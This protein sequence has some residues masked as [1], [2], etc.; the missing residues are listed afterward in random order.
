[1]RIGRQWLHR[2][3]VYA[4]I[5]VAVFS[6]VPSG[7]L[8]G[9]LYKTDAGTSLDTALSTPTAP[10][11][12]L[13]SYA[14]GVGFAS[15]DTILFNSM[16]TGAGT[17]RVSA[18]ASTNLNVSGLIFDGNT[19]AVTIQ[20]GA[21]AGTQ[22]LTIGTGG[23]D[24]SNALANVT[25]SNNSATNVLAVSLGDF[26]NWMVGAG[27]TLRI[28]SVISEAVPF[29]F[30]GISVGP[31]S[32]NGLGGTVNLTAA[33]TFTGSS[34]VAGSIL[35]LDYG[36]A[37]DRIAS[38]AALTLNR[39]T[40]SISGAATFQQNVAA[41]EL[42]RGANQITFTGTT[43][44][45]N[46]ATITRSSYDALLNVGTASRASA[47]AVN[48]N[49]IIGGWAVLNKTDW[50]INN[51]SNLIIAL[52][53]AGYVAVAA[54]AYTDKLDADNLLL[55]GS[56]T[57][58]L[59][60]SINSIKFASGAFNLTQTAG[61][62]LNLQSGG[63]LK[64]D[65]NASTISGGTITAGGTPDSFADSL[66]VWQNQNTLTISSVIADNTDGFTT[67]MVHLVKA[68]DGTLRL[69]NTAPH[70]M[71]GNTTITGG[72]IQIGNGDAT[73]SL[74]GGDVIFAFSPSSTPLV[75]D[76][77]LVYNRTDST[78]WMQ[79]LTGFGGD[80]GTYYALRKSA[81]AATTLTLSPTVANNY[82]GVTRVEAGTI[83]AGNSAAFSPNSKYQLD[84]VTGVTLDLAGFDNTIR[85]L[86]GGGVT[87]G[88][89]T[90]G[91]AT[92]T[93]APLVID[94]LSYAGSIGGSGGLVKVGAGTQVASGSHS[95]TGTT[96]VWS[97]NL[98]LGSL[99][100]AGA[101]NVY[102]GGTLTI[103]SVTGVGGVSVYNGA[104][105]AIN[106]NSSVPWFTS[107]ANSSLT[108]GSPTS[109]AILTLADGGTN[110]AGPVG[111]AFNG[112]A[113]G[114]TKNGAATLILSGGNAF[115]GPTTV[116]NGILRLAAASKYSILPDRSTITIGA[117]GSVDLNGNT[118]T[119]GGLSGAAGATL[120]MGATTLTTGLNN[121]SGNFAGVI[122]GSGGLVK[123][124][125]GTQ[126]LSGANLF[127]GN[128]L[129]GNFGGQSGGGITI[130]A[131]GTLASTV[132][133]S[134]RGLNTV[135]AVNST[136]SLAAVT[137]SSR[138]TLAL[139]SGAVLTSTYVNG[140]PVVGS[141]T[142]DTDSTAG[143]IVK[144]D[145]SIVNP[146]VGMLV[147][148]TSIPAGSYIVQV[149]DS[150]FVLLNT[151]PTPTTTNTALTS[152]TV[153]VLNSAITGLGGFTKDGTGQ[154]LLTGNNSYSGVTTITNGDLQIGGIWNGQKFSL[155]DTLSD[156]SQLIFSAAN[157]TNL[158]FAN[159]AS[160][161]LS[162]ERVAAISGGAG[163]TTSINLFAGSNVA[164]LAIGR[165]NSSGAFT[166][167]IL[168]DNAGTWLIKE[169]TGTF[170]WNNNNTVG[171]DGIIDLRAGGF[172]TLGTGALDVLNIVR[173]S[174]N[175]AVFT[176]GVTDTFS[177][178]EGGA[179]VIRV[180]P[181]TGF[182]GALYGNQ[183]TGAGAFAAIASGTVM[184]VSSATSSGFNGV[185]SGPGG[186]TK[187]GTSVWQMYGANTYSG[188]TNANAGTLTLG[189]LSRSAGVGL[190]S[191]SD[192]RGSL[193]DAGV[194]NITGGTFN[195]NGLTETIGALRNS[196]GVGTIALVNGTLTAGAQ[197]TQTISSAFTGNLGSVLN[198]IGSA[199]TQTVTLTGNSVSFAGTVNVGTN[200]ALVLNRTTSALGD[201]ARVNLNSTGTQLTVTLADTIGSIAGTGDIVLTQ[202]LTLQEAGS[203][204]AS[205]VGYSG[206]TTNV[207][208][209]LILGGFGGLTISGN[210]AH[211]G[212]ITVSNGAALNL[213]YGAGNNIVPT[214]G[215]LTLTGGN[216]RVLSI[217]S[218]A[219]ILENAASTTL[220]PGASSIQSLATIGSYLDTGLSGLNLGAVTRAA[221]STL[222]VGARSAATSTANVNSIFGVTNAAYATYNQSTW[223]VANGTGA[224]ITGLAVFN[225]DT[226]VANQHTD[227]TAAGSN[228]GGTAATVRFSGANASDITGATTLSMGGILVTSGVG[229]NTSTISGDLSGTGNELIIHQ[230]NPLGNLVLSNVAG[231]NTVITTTG[232]GR[233]LITN[234]IAGT[235]ATNIGY[236]YL[237]LGDTTVGGS[238]TGMVGSGVI[239]NNGTLGINRNN[240]LTFGTAVISGFGNIEQL[241]SGTTTLGGANTFAGR[242]S[243]RGGTLEITSNTGLGL[244]AIGA[245]NRWANL[246]S[247][248]A[249]GTLLV[250]VAAGGSIT[251]LLNLD[252]GTLDLRSTVATTLAGPI[253][254]T[255]DSTINVSNPGAAVSHLITGEILALPGSDL[256]FNNVGGATPSTL[257]LAPTATTGG[258]WENTTI[259]AGGRLVIGNN[260]RGFIGT[261]TVNNAGL[262]TFDNNDGFYVVGNNITGAASGTL[263]ISRR[264][265]GSTYLTGDLSG[266]SGALLVATNT[267]VNASTVAEI[268]N[269]T[270]NNSIGTGPITITSGGTVGTSGI[271][272]LRTHLNQDAVFANTINLNPAHDG[273]NAKNAQFIR[274]GIG[275][276]TLSGTIN[277]GLTTAGLGT[278]RNLI[279]TEAGGKLFLNATLAGGGVS[280]LLNVVNNNILVIGGSVSNTYSGI[281]SG[282]NV[283][284]F[285][286]SGTTTLSGANTVNSVNNYIR[287]G[288]VSFTGGAA[289]NDDNDW[290]V[291]GGATLSIA[292]TETIGAL[293]MQRGAVTSIAA[294]QTLTVD[295]TVNQ[296]I[297]GSF[298]GSGN[299]TIS[300]GN[301]MAL[302]GTNVASGALQLGVTT[303]NGQIQSTNLTNAIGGFS[304]IAL[305][306]AGNTGVGGIDYVGA[307]E[308]FANNIA[309][310]STSTTGSYIAANGSGALVLSGN[311]TATGTQTLRLIGQTGGYFNPIKNRIDGAVTEAGASVLSIAMT[312]TA[313]D[314][315]FG[316]TGRWAL[317]NSNNDFSGSVT[318]NVGMLELA[319]NLKTGVETTSVFGD[320]SATR[321]VTLGSSDFD[322]RR[323]DM[324]GNTDQLGNAGFAQGTNTITPSGSV[325]TI[326]FNDPNAGTATFG[327]NIS[328][329]IINGSATTITAG[330]QLINDGTKVIVINGT[331]TAGTQGTHN[332][333]F[334]GTN[335]GTNTINGVISNPSSTQTTAVIKEGAGT[336]RLSGANTFTGT[337]TVNNGILELSGGAA[338]N[339][340]NTVA[341]SGDGGDGLYSFAKLRIVTSETFAVLTGDV[342]VETTIDAGQTLE[343]AGGNSAY[344]GMFTGVG[345]LAKTVAAATAGTLTTPAKNT[346][347]GATTLGALGA[348]TASGGISVVHLADGGVA[349]GIG[350]SS[351]AASNLVF[352]SNT[353]LNQGGI[354]TWTG[355][356]NQSTNRL[357][358]MG[359]GT[360]AA[361]ITASGALVGT[362]QATLTF[363]NT[364][365]IA[366]S[367]N[368]TR[369]LT[370]SGAG[371]GE[372][373]FRPQIS[374]NV[375][376]TT[377]AK[378]GAGLWY[379]NPG[380]AGNNYT[381]GTNITAGTLAISASNALGSGT[382]AING[383]AGVGLEIRSGVTLTQSITNSTAEGGI[384]VTGGSSIMSN[385]VTSSVNFRVAVEAGASLEWNNATA[386][387][388]GAGQLIKIG[389]GTLILSGVNNNTAATFVR[390]GVLELN[391]AVN[392]TSKLADGV[393]L[394]LGS[395]AG[396]LVPGVDDNVP[397][398]NNTY[399]QGGGTIN[400]SGGSHIE[401]VSATTIDTGSNAVTRT[402]GTSVLRM[403]AITRGVNQ[404]TIDFGA[405]GIADTDTTNT[406][407]ILGSTTTGAFATVAKTDWAFNSTNAADGAINALATY[408]VN[409]FATGSNTDITSAAVSTGA[410]TLNNTFRFNTPQA[411][412]L[413]LG[414][415]FGVQ[416]TAV[417][418]QAGGILVTPNVGAFTTTIT[419]AALQNAAATANFAIIVH[420]HNTAGALQINSVIQNNT[421]ATAQGLTKTG[422]GKLFLT[423]LNTYTGSLNLYEGE[424]QVGGTAAAPT[425][426]TNAYL[427]ALGA[428]TQG[429]ALNLAIDT[430]LRFL[431]TNTAVYNTGAITGGGNIILDTGNLGVLLF[432]DANTGYYGNITVNQGTIQVNAQNAALGD[433]RGIT[434]IGSLGILQFNDS[435]SIGEFITYSQGATVTTLAAAAGVL[436]GKQTL[437]NSTAA[438]LTFNI[439]T[440]SVVGTVGLN[441]SGVSYGNN[442]F[443]K[444][445]SGILQISGTNFADVYDGY[446]ALGTAGTRT[447][448][449]L[450]QILINQGTLY[451]GAT[452]ALGAF[453]VG[454]ET[455]VAAGAS[456]DL[457]GIAL[458]IGDD[459]DPAREIL[460][461]QGTG[462]VN[463]QGNSTGALR[464]STGTG[465]VSFVTLDGNATINSG[466]TANASA[467]VI[468][469]FDTNLSN[470]NS[471]TG[472]FTRQ[473]PVIAGG[474]F[475]L[476][477]QG[478]RVGTDNFVIADPTF[479][480]ALNR[481]IIREGGARFRHE[482]TAVVTPVG[483]ANT[484]ITA[485]I[486]IGYGG[487]TAADLTGVAAGG[488]GNTTAI[489]GANV[490]AR[491]LFENFY[492]SHNTVSIAMNGVLAAAATG[493]P[494]GTFSLAGGH[495]YLSADFATIP[496]GTTYLDG[497]LNL[498]GSAIRNII[499]ND[500]VGNYSVTEQGN[501]TVA[502]ATKL[503][504]GGVAQGTGGFTKIGQADVRFTNA[505][506]FSGDV[507]VLRLGFSA[508][509]WESHTYKINGVDYATNGLGEGW[510]EYSLTLN[511]AAGAFTDVGTITL[512]RRGMLTLDNTNRLDATSGVVGGNNN[513]RI[514]DDAVLNLEHGWFRVTAGTTANSEVLGTV[515]VNSGANLLDLYGTDGAGVNIN[516]TVNTLN[517]VAGGVL[518]INN[519]DATSTFST[520]TA[521]DSAKVT[522]LTLNVP[523]IGGGGAVNTTTRSIVQGVFGGNAPISLS[524]DLR[525]LGFNNVNITDLWNQVRNLEFAA[526][527][528]FMTYEGTTLRPLDDDEYFA[529]ADG[530]LNPTSLGS[531]TQNVNLSDVLTLVS[532]DATVNSLRLGALTD[533][534]GTGA[535]GLIDH[536]AVS[537]LV[538]G[539]L[540]ISSGMI[541][542]AYWT[543]GNTSSAST[544]I[545]GGAL[546]FDGKEA[547][548]NVQNAFYNLTLGAISGGTMSL[549]SAITNALGLTKVGF[550]QLN[551]DGANTYTGVT[552][553]SDGTLFL[554]NGRS[555]LGAGGFGNGVVII[556]NG[557]LN[558]GNGL[559]VGTPSA[560]E[561]IYVGI[562]QASQQIMR[563]DNDVTVWNSNLIIDN[564][565][566]SGQTQFTPIIR[567][568]NGATSIINGNIVGGNTPVSNDVLGNDPRR[569]SFNSAG[570]NVFIVR[571]Q[572]GDRL[573]GS[574][575]AVPIAD[576]I[577][578]LPTLTG[579]RT[580][581]NEVLRVDLGGASLETNYIFDRQYNAAGRL[582]VESGNLIVNYDPAGGGLDGTGYWTNT[583]ISKIPNADSTTTAF[584]VNGGS[585]FQGFQLGTTTGTGVNNGNAGL[586]LSRA[587]QV[588]NMAS[589]TMA[590][591]G[592]KYIG[593][594]NESGTVAFGNGTGDLT[595]AGATASLY[596]ADG[597][598]V[599]FNQ[600]ML[601]VVGTAPSA[602]G[603]VKQGRGTVEL[604]NTTSTT[605]STADFVIAGGT[606]MLNHTALTSVAL[607]G[608]ANARFDGGT[609]ISI[610]SSGANTTEGFA[611]TSAANNVLNFN[612]GGTE[613]V[614][615][616]VNTGTARNMTI[617]MGNANANATTSNFTRTLGATVNLVEDQSAGGTA[618]ITLEFNA[619]STAAIKNQVIPWATY[620]TLSR[621][622]TDFAMS[623]SASANDVRAYGR[624][625]G[626]YLNDVTAWALNQDVSESGGPGF[627]GTLTGALTLSTLRFDANADSLVDLGANVLTVAGNGL[628]SS[629]GGI[630]VSS[631]V[632]A[633]N[634]TITGTTGAALTTSGGR[635]ELIIHQYALG[636]LNINVPIT[637]AGVDLVISGPSTTNVAT[638]GTTGA[639]VLGA[640]NTY[641]GQTFING[642]VLSFSDVGQLGTRANADAIQ[643]NGGTLRYT[644]ST[645]QTLGT[646][647]IVFSGNG[648]TIDVVDGG[649]E[650]YID[651]LIASALQFRGDMIKVG[652]GTLTVNGNSGNNA[653]FLGLIDVRQGT[654]RINSNVGNANAGTITPLGS[655]ASYADGTVFR[656]GT[657]F[658][659]Q[660]GNANDAAAD[661]NLEEWLTFE[662]NNYV[663][664]GTI[665]TQTG[666]VSVTPG[667]LD[668]NN[669]R[670]VNLNGVITIKGDVVFDVVGGQTLRFNNGGVG[671]T[672]GNGNIIKDGQGALQFQANSPDFTGSITV[673]QG[674][675]YGVGQ[676]DFFGTGYTAANGNKTI[677]LGSADRQGIAELS[678][679]SDSISGGTMEL[680]H[681][682]N[683]VYNPAQGKRLYFE[684]FTNGSQIEVNGDITFNDNLNIYINDAAETGGSQNYV[685]VNSKLLDGLTTSGNILL[686]ADDGGGGANDNTNGRP[687][688]YLVLKNNN[689]G[690]TGD[691][692][693][694][695]NTSYDQDQTAI[696]RLEHVN[697]LTAANDVDMGFN[698]MLQVG[699]GAR[700][701]GSLSTNG[702]VGPFIGDTAGGTMG[703]STNG[704][705]VVIENA[706]ATVGTLTITQTTPVSTEVVWNAYFRNGTLNSEFFA[707]GAGPVA[708]AALNLVKAGNGWATIANDNSYTGTTTVTGGLLQVGRGNVG[709][710]GAA[711]AAGLIANTGT[712]IAGTGVIQGNST[713]NGVLSPGDEGGSI[714]GTIMVNGNLSLGAASNTTMQLQRASYTAFNVLNMHDANY[715]AWSG[716][717][718]GDPSY[719]HLL[720]DPVTTAQHDKLIVTGGLAVASGGKFSLINT[721]YNPT[722]GDVIN[723]LDWIGGT[724]SLN[725]GG[726]A[727]N[728]GLFRTGL[729][730]G[731]DLDLFQLGNGL[732]YDVSQFNATGNILVAQ[733]NA[734]TFYWN[735]DQS[736]SWSTNN[737]GNTNWLD[738]PN[739]IDVG[740]TPS[741]TDDVYFVATSAGN[742][743][744]TLGANFAV[745]SLNFGLG[746]N[747]GTSASI[748]TGVNTLTISN[749][750]N[751]SATSAAN[752]ISGI[753]GIVLAQSQTWTNASPTSSLIVAAPISG[754][755]NLTTA[756]AGTIIFS[757]ANTYVGATTIGPGV[758]QLG[759]ASTTGSLSPSGSIVN[760][761]T[762]SINRSNAV[763]QGT[764]FSV[765]AITGPG[766]LIQAGVGTTTLTAAN[767]YLG[768]TTIS[769]GTL[770]LGNGGTT[771][772]LSTSSVITNNGTFAVN[773][774][775]AVTQGTDFSGAPI[776]G[777]GGFTQTGGG[778]TTFTAANSY[779]GPTLVSA[780]TLRVNGSLTQTSSV[781]VSG[782]TLN[783]GV[784][785]S[786]STITSAISVSATGQ[787]SPGAGSGDNGHGVGRMNVTGDVTWAG[788]SSLVFDFATNT[789]GVAGTN[790]DLLSLTG[791]SDLIYSGTGKINLQIDSWV[792]NLSAYGK[793][794]G[795]DVGPGADDFNPNIAGSPGV[796]A[797]SWLWVDLDTANGGTLNN[798]T[799]APVTGE[800]GEFNIDVSNSNVYNNYGTIGGTFWVSAVSSKLY[801]NYSASAVPEPGSLLLVGLA[802]IG[803]AGY[804]RLRKKPTQLD[805]T[806]NIANKE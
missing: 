186:L 655:N 715:G 530:V 65:N 653:G 296:L 537:V 272:S 70:T 232:G 89:V 347:T 90:L 307:G 53:T 761:G 466:G 47:N 270:Y 20:S 738:G 623:S 463:A 393:A 666:N 67:D 646:K 448:T 742:M 423:G 4:A 295:D 382:I 154:L 439:P 100:G 491:L 214:T 207:A 776:T 590:G 319:G 437:N 455:L 562:L 205:A 333:V 746:V 302:Y 258:R 206:V 355:F 13:Q 274:A 442:G 566:I 346:Y 708:S 122:S 677:T 802:G 260:T 513:N 301:Y 751:Q 539:T 669:E 727:F 182:V 176:N 449:L 685:N 747:T 602:F 226:F 610:A 405:S 311:L 104:K 520:A 696:L 184:T 508:A 99:T 730:V 661:Y 586:F 431:T 440:A 81:G 805:Q 581:E 262:L 775:N 6:G 64:N 136:N 641:D 194:L 688:N 305:G 209:A 552:T 621:T 76:G 46:L 377:L 493:T 14:D 378:T 132:A 195:L 39:S 628:A 594:L 461:I 556:G 527:S 201:T 804:R 11:A 779:F 369:T 780:G 529:P 313:N 675:L 142:A 714:R 645:L 74:P 189:V 123:V 325:G 546:D 28:D 273:T 588:F 678:I 280:N 225:A 786:P 366:Y 430:T 42:G 242:V 290:H 339:D 540:K 164:A 112:L 341:I 534:D 297:A 97:G 670:P 310:T 567:T 409:T 406:S 454:N 401:V 777:T 745:N 565:D 577:S 698:S 515:N 427:G 126:T 285:N 603:Y 289:S 649:A 416:G 485:G 549:Q 767:A 716:G 271:A 167:N 329:A 519:L 243:V 249:G 342:G 185:I 218:S 222:D 502:P 733:A 531:A 753:G 629:G 571:G 503:I 197:T 659:I 203:G 758:L 365:P 560:R 137:G 388:A 263:A 734:R 798:F 644:G 52:P 227:I 330:G 345:G 763:V 806:D 490:G 412:T 163:T 259:N 450:G 118:E 111:E 49:G 93:L 113:G 316:I 344:N 196:T 785:G 363:S 54:G 433:V 671:Y 543:A 728:G 351:N 256:T 555:A 9:T 265:S 616:T 464:N 468:G 446:S 793:N 57:A 173:V 59:D 636:N 499:V 679:N 750:I 592:A 291:F 489:L 150:N 61:T 68:G 756:G 252:G 283:W 391:Y 504:F 501:L 149:L 208:G 673:A 190:V 703:A 40:L 720:N 107:E 492:A 26:Q 38:S 467:M 135:F 151:Q 359:D 387:Y 161:L 718:A 635:V 156:A 739:G 726:I 591:T 23:I 634:K 443:T 547:I 683:V 282:N 589:W 114:L 400:L 10:G 704:T 494:G 604:R 713:I 480:S 414:A 349:S 741:F 783:G 787:Y 390:D 168:G 792:N 612:I 299:L 357:F 178:L 687:Y 682:L 266:F 545:Y 101:I 354:L 411:A 801:I 425:T 473:R 561:D 139:G 300:G 385:T 794:H 141:A 705:T 541:S 706:A 389:N 413:T 668:P 795:S 21:V 247:V 627:G 680:N 472:A 332:W 153:S 396:L 145:G 348:A 528:H 254:L 143:R 375:G 694:S 773:R 614:A 331:L 664:V 765:A 251:E 175:N 460:K 484:D 554:R 803:L 318:V 119:V 542:S 56:V 277:L 788:G 451:V 383:G 191:G 34:F 654:L 292:A 370:L 24:M 731:T 125:S 121:S 533:H 447:P 749:G 452:R 157:A 550:Q 462:V 315:R 658:A 755:A 356:T 470:A 618:Q 459:S 514:A 486:E 155:H 638:I 606:L 397:G 152:T 712:T 617:N 663:S 772:S 700:T 210:L 584:A 264:T 521:G 548:I 624:V 559:V 322:G 759:A 129:I 241:G 410:A 598:T 48:I 133:V 343:L 572:I 615:R 45:V 620:G 420:Q 471:L 444:S 497:T 269:D 267:T 736:A 8:A 789:T 162:F 691:I 19:G 392:N 597:G 88:N 229:A 340:A 509:P 1:M 228:G 784:S 648:G 147:T 268:G 179:G 181:T 368:G 601:G 774:S 643:M 799:I 557:S 231:T 647:G 523:Q 373:V 140:T 327:A 284:V 517:R 386:A 724:L 667:F 569:L 335:T 710:T 458:N 328:W 148:G 77:M 399:G 306:A 317:T 639:V 169:G 637:G 221:G 760:N 199:A 479:S 766:A 735:G 362:S 771:G 415:A 55:N 434:T 303:L 180:Q 358:T 481:L 676:A 367:G 402:S 250:N 33:N 279:Q 650:L 625:P 261:G 465:Q 239:L 553:I 692:R 281:L 41:T 723:L 782:G 308:T 217:A 441:I 536:H 422:A 124:G 633:A 576:P 781:T 722:A 304:S 672:T 662:G 361:T 376:A 96:E 309:L 234:N 324:F 456:L 568:D 32:L 674:R 474:G 51:G 17:S 717:I 312:N 7:A 558:S 432:D 693:V 146:Q 183:L 83:A 570:N 103:G 426:P 215:A 72:R 596:A 587:G 418:L 453:G 511:G 374:D 790:W 63:I 573:D 105:L 701:I 69:A 770:Q 595:F 193:S 690:W 85:G 522:V 128:I 564:V 575:N 223:A 12:I 532:R 607:V 516:L 488:Q 350:A 204:A 380:P 238:A 487:L 127:A 131:G 500:S 764:D 681:A 797:Y 526:G 719:S 278:Q 188:E 202:S 216:V 71:T 791:T 275:N 192:I 213:N 79:N 495:N 684:T 743:G 314:D 535:T 3:A 686:S 469:T 235:G 5:L 92:L 73:G 525:V 652:A 360:L 709:D 656:T 711:G 22:T 25:L 605:A 91:S 483:I 697:A 408:A 600:R 224:A 237:Q 255:S 36:T 752:T 725:L 78:T 695:T 245:T 778:V 200:A 429:N 593:G 506:T 551:L 707:P 512:Q 754:S 482:I 737:A 84:N 371:I 320:L 187:A 608:S 622:A 651:E 160:N 699:G 403:N 372:N 286:N 404:G 117:T 582:T 384:N 86:S 338:I 166:G 337:T 248:N 611:T 642:S 578:L 60:D 394:T 435:R 30:I 538:D 102:A 585:V 219:G 253:V 457:R 748:D 276:L 27:R 298:S 769:A 657:G 211:T 379:V 424:I 98:T 80:D 421:S 230:Y 29:S 37:A 381:G 498:S 796:P 220:N 198:L 87:G 43:A 721:G 364:G 583:A 321:V 174:N 50:A 579:T 740:S 395:I 95:Y 665:N 334:D 689:S 613:I 287:Q 640:V 732:L 630:L 632:G 236:G 475:D 417:G 75:N 729:E 323:Y 476:T 436:S 563:T 660:L 293:Y 171:F 15:G 116:N 609:I 800:V 94:S 110:I 744:T 438:G 246:T 240:A 574:G 762:L 134:N 626:E 44:T 82:F 478:G 244:A 233:T 352:V 58:V 35:A 326:I 702:G 106:A 172:T 445:G 108:L 144:L 257:I 505:N 510:A 398:Q 580:N 599:V 130:G 631:N 524:S 544:I 428:A 518:R 288:I 294:G 16:I 109:G 419:G 120:L 66:F 757:G 336:W 768:T 158:N 170:T 177:I 115:T 477:V 138:T 2:T 496:D 507:N 619:S 212:G 18:A 353:A 159:S 165:D 31:S 407:G 62:T